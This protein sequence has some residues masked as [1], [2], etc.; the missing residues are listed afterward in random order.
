MKSIAIW[1]PV[2]GLALHAVP[3]GDQA[4]RS[5]ASVVSLCDLPPQASVSREER[6]ANEMRR[7]EDCSLAARFGRTMY[8]DAGGR[9]REHRASHLDH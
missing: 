5:T 6:L 7:E 1:L 2:F 8:R 9:L 4:G 3:I